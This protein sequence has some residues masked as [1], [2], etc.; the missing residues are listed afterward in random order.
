MLHSLSHPNIVIC[1]GVAVMPPAICLVTEWCHHGSLYDLLHTSEYFICD[2]LGRMSSSKRSHSNQARLSLN[3]RMSNTQSNGDVDSIN[4][5]TSEGSAF[6]DTIDDPNTTNPINGEK[7][8]WSPQNLRFG[9]SDRGSLIS[10]FRVISKKFH[11]TTTRSSLPA[12]R[13][14][15]LEEE[16]SSEVSWK[17][18]DHNFG[19]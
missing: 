17:G 14:H 5:V 1:H 8:R 18:Q 2:S 13:A 7:T 11:T 15:I 12:L 6:D 4:E 16:G 3:I 19:E 10:D 9:A